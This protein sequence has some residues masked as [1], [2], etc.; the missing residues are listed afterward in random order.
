MNGTDVGVCPFDF[1][2]QHRYL[3]SYQ[4]AGFSNTRILG[5]LTREPAAGLGLRHETG[6]LAHGYSADL[7]V[8][9]GDPLADLTA[10]R[11]ILLV[12]ARGQQYEPRRVA[13]PLS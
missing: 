11:R 7:I 6:I 10:L 8:V 1:Y 9:D 13:M 2:P 5:I 12:V 4:A 3:M